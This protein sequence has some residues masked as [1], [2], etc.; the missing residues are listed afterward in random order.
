M[1]LL[2]RAALGLTAGT[3][4]VGVGVAVAPAATPKTYKATL[5]GANVV[6][7]QG[8]RDGSGTAT[9]RITGTRLCYT[10]TLSRV[11]STV[12]GHIHR[13]VAGKAGPVAQA[14]YMGTEDR[15]DCVTVKSLLAS[16]IAANPGRFY[17]QLHNSKFPDGA[18]RGQLRKG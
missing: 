4:A 12:G 11:A 6:P 7:K 18:V 8:D 3:L 13:G 15:S 16:Q 17:V 5:K 10:L 14:F 1:S 9:V 2:H